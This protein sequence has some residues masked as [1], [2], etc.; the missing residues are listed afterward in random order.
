ML[1]L[2]TS[3]SLVLALALCLSLGA[4]LASE[5]MHPAART[6]P[7]FEQLK[8]LAGTWHGTEQQRVESTLTYQVVS[9]GS[10]VMERLQGAK[11]PEMITMYSLDG[12]RILVTHYCSA[13]NQPTMQSAPLTAATGKFDFSFVRLAGAS[14]PD[15]GHMVALTL[16]LTDKDHLTQDWTFT[17]HGK[18]MTATFSFTRV[19]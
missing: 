1:H 9:N 15:E 6:T 2:R 7:A 11:E 4:A 10:V 5:E 13:G 19:K 12:D 16:T 18:T 14:S 3:V 8:S 17:D